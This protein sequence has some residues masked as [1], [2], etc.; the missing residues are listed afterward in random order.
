MIFIIMDCMF[1]F[2]FRQLFVC[3][4]V[5]QSIIQ[6]SLK[7]LILILFFSC[8]LIKAEAQEK[9]DTL[10][11]QK[12]DSLT[13]QQVDTLIKKLDTVIITK[14]PQNITPTSSF[15]R[16]YA[17]SYW[18]DT[19]SLA[20]NPFHWKTGQIITAAAVVAA[21]AGLIAWGDKPI[22]QFYYRNSSVFISKTSYYFFSPLGSGLY[23]IPTLGIFYACGVIWKNKKAKETGLK[24]LEAFVIT[25]VITQ[26][27]KQVTHRHRPYQDTPPNPHNWDGPFSWGGEYGMFGYN[28]FPSGHSSTAFSIATVISL[29]YWDTKW[30][31]IVCFGL[32]GLTAAYRL[33]MNDHW[34]SD[35]LFGS[36]LGFAVGSMV[37]FN[38][39]KKLQIIPVSSTGI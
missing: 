30:V 22:Q 2:I 20:T 13:P 4:I 28:S 26:V 37:F 15:G 33:A 8:M 11:P 3:E 27:I 21:T 5:I 32:A 35:V 10:T 24:G 39:N 34:A 31:P 29:E 25:A 7:A 36:A 1:T 16:A 9:K 38:A 23:D 12:I 19:K 6:M 18:T 14:E 17:S